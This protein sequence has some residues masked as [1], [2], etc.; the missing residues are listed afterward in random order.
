M[1][2]FL[3]IEGIANFAPYAVSRGW[4]PAH[5]SVDPCE[6]GADHA[7]RPKKIA[8]KTQQHNLERRFHTDPEHQTKTSDRGNSPQFAG[9]A[10]S[11]AISALS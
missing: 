6:Q 4:R 3:P 5:T 10:R 9:H 1:P 11:H 2:A 7:Q 8:G